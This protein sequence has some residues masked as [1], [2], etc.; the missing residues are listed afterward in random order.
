MSQAVY[1]GSITEKLKR[2]VEEVNLKRS[3]LPFTNHRQIQTHK[4]T[5][6]QGEREAGWDKTVLRQSSLGR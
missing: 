1:L 2:R 4:H 5:Q 3:C 6:G